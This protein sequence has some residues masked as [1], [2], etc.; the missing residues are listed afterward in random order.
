[1]VDSGAD[2][3]VDFTDA[4]VPSTFGVPPKEIE[5]IFKTLVGSLEATGS[6][7]IVV[8]VADGL[9]HA[10]TAA[11]I[12]SAAFQDRVGGII[13]AAGDALGA[14]AGVDTLPK[15]G[16]RVLCV[17]GVVTASPLAV[18]EAQR[19]TG[20]TVTSLLALPEEG[21]LRELLATAPT[22]PLADNASI[23]A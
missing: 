7:V 9:C 3:V 8:E 18:I 19:T 10:E 22:V 16:L 14:K 21:P 6:D 2:R 17:S 20:L 4:G 11:L 12:A 5:A 1:M 13:F 23:A 15:L